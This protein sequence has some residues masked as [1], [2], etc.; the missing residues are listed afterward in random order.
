MESHLSNEHNTKTNLLYWQNVNAL[1]KLIVVCSSARK[2]YV[3]VKQDENFY[4][5]QW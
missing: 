2:T 5:L 4:R 1:L 3:A